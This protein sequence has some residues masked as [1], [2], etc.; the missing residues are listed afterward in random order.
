MKSSGHN[1]NHGSEMTITALATATAVAK[2]QTQPEPRF[3]E[4]SQPTHHQ[5]ENIYLYRTCMYIHIYIRKTY[6]FL[7]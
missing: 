4:I 5:N 1:L 2:L 6:G 7:K 3:S